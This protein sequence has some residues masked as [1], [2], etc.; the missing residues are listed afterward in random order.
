MKL[1]LTS[2]GLE[3]KA[4]AHY[5][6][7]EILVKDASTLSLLLISIQDSEQDAFYLQKTLSEIRATGILDIDVF[8]LFDKKFFSEKD[9][10]I[11]FVC[12]GNTFDYL[13]RIRKT[14]LDKYIM[15][16]AKK[17][18]SIY[19]GVSAGSIIVGPSVEIAGWGTAA[20]EN[21]LGLKDLSGL[22]LTDYIIYPHYSEE[23]K[24]ELE[25]FK[26]ISKNKV[27]ELRDD[28]AIALNCF[29][30]KIIKKYV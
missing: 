19:I 14:G 20:D 2:T 17:E 18:E 12:G 26:K 22:G 11:V 29:D 27:I 24:L 10:D 16:F 23:L 9:Y 4:I 7:T 6:K 30:D 1:F 13:D 5:F 8:E 3:N 28:Q 21:N 25:E 15:S